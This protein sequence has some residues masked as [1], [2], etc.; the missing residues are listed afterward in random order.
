MIGINLFE[1]RDE[2]VISHWVEVG[3]KECGSE[4]QRQGEVAKW[5]KEE[6]REFSK[7]LVMATAFKNAHLA[8]TTLPKDNAQI[9]I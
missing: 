6:E 1:H 3:C 2:K 8:E 5:R 4:N 9:E 7:L